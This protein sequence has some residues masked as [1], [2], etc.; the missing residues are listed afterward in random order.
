[1][2]REIQKMIGLMVRFSNEA[3]MDIPQRFIDDLK[4][5]MIHQT[6][7]D[8]TGVALYAPQVARGWLTFNDEI[9]EITVR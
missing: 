2:T 5:Q 1:M 4:T 8:R 9:S 6:R 7:N 3:N